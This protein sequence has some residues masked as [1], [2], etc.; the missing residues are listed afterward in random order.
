MRL[1]RLFSTAK[2][3]FPNANTFI[4]VHPG[5]NGKYALSLSD[6]PKNDIAIVGWS[7]HE[8]PLAMFKDFE[9]NE[10][11]K[12]TIHSIMKRTFLEIG[13]LKEQASMHKEGWMHIPDGRTL[14]PF[15]RCPDPEDIFATVLVRD[16]QLVPGKIEMMPTHRLLTIN[17]LFR[18]PGEFDSLLKREFLM[19]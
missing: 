1:Q 10:K 8:S 18:L 14:T 11:L 7:S 2:F 4:Y 3:K 17:G 16:G 6:K 19:K 15:G 9:Q 13:W 5:L 12:A